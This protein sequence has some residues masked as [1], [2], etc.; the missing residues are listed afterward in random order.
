[1]NE[2]TEQLKAALNTELAREGKLQRAGMRKCVRYRDEDKEF[3]KKHGLQPPS[4]EHW[5]LLHESERFARYESLGEYYF[6]GFTQEVRAKELVPVAILES[7]H[8]TIRLT[9]TGDIRFI[10]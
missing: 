7:E 3:N 6:H 8:G 4:L 1:M 5:K 10:T 2:R 9:P